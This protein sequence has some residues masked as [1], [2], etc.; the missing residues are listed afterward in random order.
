M[1]DRALHIRKNGSA[2]REKKG[3]PQQFPGSSYVEQIAT[4][5]LDFLT[6]DWLS[7]C[8]YS[9][10]SERT[11]ELRRVLL[12][13]LQWF[14]TDR[15]A[16]DCG[17]SELRGFFAYLTTGH[18]QKGGRWGYGNDHGASRPMSSATIRTY[19]AHLR[20]FFNW[21]VGQGI[22]DVSPLDSLSPPRVNSDQ[23]QPFTKDQ[24]ESLLK[25]AK[26]GSYPKRD[27]AILMFLLDT[28]VRASELCTI[29]MKDVDLYERHAQVTGKGNKR[30][31]ICFGQRCARILR[32]Y[33]RN[34]YRTPDHPLFTA[35]R[36]EAPLTRSG[37]LQLVRKTGKR[38]GVQVTRC[39]PHT[40][41][42]TFAIEFL[43]AGGNVFTLQQLMGHTGLQI[44][45]RYV[46]L[47][48][49]DIQNQHRQFS[50]VDRLK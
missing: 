31:T 50:P 41:R 14:L 47:A 1:H 3:R 13:R 43:R 40:F 23:I 4:E 9:Q 8:E 48:Q 15:Q 24:S 45:Q 32:A 12:G 37:L 25:A 16:T 46:A 10:R 35:E 22:I 19:Y 30:R 26:D 42:H 7:D 33:L 49:A 27:E 18:K 11:I 29:K 28:G 2:Q 6:E 21:L 5:Q 20:S 38:A 17:R 44:T 36:T 39:S 34:E